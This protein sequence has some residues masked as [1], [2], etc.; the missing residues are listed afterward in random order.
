MPERTNT[1]Q[2]VAR[3]AL[4]T[5]KERRGHIVYNPNKGFYGYFE[6][7]AGALVGPFPTEQDVRDHARWC[8][9][10][11][12]DGGELLK[13]LEEGSPELEELR[14]QEVME[15]TPEEDKQDTGEED[16]KF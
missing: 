9:D 14:R 8:K 3:R 7:L 2:T 1:D 16:P 12:G 15:L 11:R 4:A 10:V 5:L 13:I 6:D